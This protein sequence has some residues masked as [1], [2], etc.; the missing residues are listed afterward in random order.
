MSNIYLYDPGEF[1]AG[2]YFTRI[3]KAAKTTDGRFIIAGTTASSE[4][5]ARSIRRKD[6]S[7]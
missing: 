4:K 3:I 2:G 1:L 6:S 7:S 5:S